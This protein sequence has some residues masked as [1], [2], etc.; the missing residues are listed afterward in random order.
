MPQL[1]PP[2][3]PEPALAQW[4]QRL[5]EV[6]LPR[7]ASDMDL[8]PLGGDQVAPRRL[9]EHALHEPAFALEVLREANARRRAGEELR[10]LEHGLKLLGTARA[11]RLMRLREAEPFDPALLAHRLCL[12][13]MASTR[14]GWLYLASDWR[15]Q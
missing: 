2:A 5:R 15:S 4:R 7:L 8:R 12:A 13:A 3:A 1:L 6:Q 11:Q 9:L 14:L 10:G